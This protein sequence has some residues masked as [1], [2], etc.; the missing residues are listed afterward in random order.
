MLVQLIL[1]ILVPY[2]LGGECVQ[3]AS[4]GDITFEVAN[5]T[6][7]NVAEAPWSVAEWAV[8]LRFNNS[9][10]TVLALVLG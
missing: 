4:E 6:L 3:G 10:A 7:Y 1:V 2:G 9:R 8:A 5:P